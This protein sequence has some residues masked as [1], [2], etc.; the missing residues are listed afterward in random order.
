MEALNNAWS[1]AS[2]DIYQEQQGAEGQPGA[3]G[4]PQAE[5]GGE[6]PGGEAKNEAEDVEFEEVEEA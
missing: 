2:Q 3:D 5:A 6:E 1:A 4:G